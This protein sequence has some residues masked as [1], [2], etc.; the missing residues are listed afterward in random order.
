LT[1]VFLAVPRKL[2]FFLLLGAALGGHASAPPANYQIDVWRADDGLPQS[3]VTSIVQSSD[4]YLWLGTQNGLVR[5]DGARFV[6]FDERNTPAIK[7]SRIVRLYKDRDDSL[8]IGTEKAGLVRLRN[9]QFASFELPSRQTTH[10]YP[11]DICNDASGALWLVS[12]EWQLVRFGE[13]R[14]TIPSTGWGLFGTT[15]RAV[16]ADR[17]GQVWVGTENELAVGENG[18]FRSLWSRTNEANFQVEFMAPSLFGG[19]W[20]AAN[21]RLRRFDAHKWADDLGA[22]AWTN[23]PIY[24]LFEDSRH[25]LWVATLGGGLFRYDVHGTALHLTTKEGLPTDSVRC[26]TEDREGNVWVGTEGGGLCRLKPALFQTLG[27]RQGLASDQV[28]STC[29]LREGGLL[30]G[31]D[32]GGLDC[33]KDGKIEHYGP[34]RGLRNG[35]V[36]SVIQDRHGTIWAGTW[37]GLYRGDKGVFNGLSDGAKIGWQVLAIYEDPQNDLWLGQQAFGALSR[38]HDGQWSL[39]NIPGASAGLDVRVIVRDRDGDLWIGTNDEGLYRLKDGKVTRFARKDGLG[40][41]SIWSLLVDRQGALWVGTCR[42]GLSRWLNGRFV[43]WTT[44]QGLINDV[45]CQI[46]EDNCGNL[47]LGS[48]G[49]VFRINRSELDDAITRPDHTIHCFA[50]GKADGLPSIECQGGFQPSGCKT[51]D[52][53]LWFP[54]IKGLAVADVEAVTTNRLPPPVVIEEMI[55]DGVITNRSKIPPG[56]QSVGFRYTALSLTEPEKVRFKTRLENLDKDW[57]DAGSSRIA[58]Y[59]RLPAGDYRFHVT[60]C[61]NDGVWNDKGATLA[62]TIL[63]HFWQTGWFLTLAALMAV[64]LI[65][66]MVR[67]IERRRTQLRLQRLE[68]ETAVE[69]ERARIAKDIHDDLGAS[70][71]EITILSELAHNPGIPPAQAQADVRKIGAK[72]RSLTQLLDEI[73]WAL[74]PKKDTLDNFVTYACTF[75]QDYLSGGKVQCRLEVPSEVPLAPLS[76]DVRHSLFL[77]M[78]EALSNVLKHADAKEVNLRVTIDDSVFIFGIEDDGKGIEAARLREFMEAPNGHRNGLLNMRQRTESIGGEFEICSEPAG[79][80]RVRL[81]V[82]IHAQ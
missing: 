33:L 82:P 15:A 45:I 6:V 71:T 37:D 20:V 81:K 2:L 27:V 25:C 80:T 31:T 1:Q 52:G 46:L 18:S 55:V 62:F 51:R 7:N 30:I 67:L 3:S 10:N 77:V 56:K 66:G 8:W 11:R 38:L 54:T 59:S 68:R 73:V 49:G 70:L 35:N 58:D 39:V 36:W 42:G 28:M 12:C 4:G 53:R 5:F 34:D 64:A 22:Y 65:S 63:P 60:A 43:T 41:D 29:E 19:V 17:T 61:N 79:G 50:Y 13:D 21:D 48:Y 78:K 24:D 47:W 74:N 9:G 75:A 14:F 32:G 23:R 57:A 72:A 16:A 26:V 69:R 76:S 40:N 44:Q